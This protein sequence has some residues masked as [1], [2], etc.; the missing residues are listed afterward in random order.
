[1]D[2]VH[3]LKLDNGLVAQEVMFVA[4]FHLG[5]QLMCPSPML[6]LPREKGYYRGSLTRVMFCPPPYTLS[7]LEPVIV[8]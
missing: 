3:W 5:G 4:L 8:Y 2:E 1:M 6:S 7:I